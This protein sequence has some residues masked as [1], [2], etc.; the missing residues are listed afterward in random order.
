MNMNP[1]KATCPE[2]DESMDKFMDLSAALEKQSSIIQEEAMK[3]LQA[4][5][6]PLIKEKCKQMACAWY[7]MCLNN[8][9]KAF[10]QFFQ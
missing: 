10:K 7:V 6:C 5:T 8:N 4:R 1:S 2:E 3:Y 9:M